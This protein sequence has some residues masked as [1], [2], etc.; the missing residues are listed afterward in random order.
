MTKF[1]KFLAKKVTFIKNIVVPLKKS[2][3]HQSIDWYQ[4]FRLWKM[5]EGEFLVYDKEKW[6]H[7]P[8]KVIA[9]NMYIGTNVFVY[10]RWLVLKV[11]YPSVG[12]EN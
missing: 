8:K 5:H 2:I 11:Q 3:S 10:E 12:S 7:H 4:C 1:L 9:L 6:W